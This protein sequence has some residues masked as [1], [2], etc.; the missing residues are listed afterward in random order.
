[1]V[2]VLNR[3]P[4]EFKPALGN[5]PIKVLDIKPGEALKILSRLAY[6]SGTPALRNPSAKRS[7]SELSA[8]GYQ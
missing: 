4:A 2:P 1:M 6:Y 7:A 3:P 8:N 5:T